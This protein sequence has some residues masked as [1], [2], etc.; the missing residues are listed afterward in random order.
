MTQE[1][2]NFGENIRWRPSAF[3]RPK[4]EAELL[5]ILS[6]HKG[7]KIRPVASKHSWSPVAATTGVTLDMSAFS[8]VE[9]NQGEDDQVFARVGAGCGLQALLDELH[10]GSDWTL[11][12]LGAVKQQTIAGAVSTGT[13][14]SGSPGLSHFVQAARIARYNP[15]SGE[16]EMVTVNGGQE[17]RAVRCGLGCTGVLV[18]LTLSCRPQYLVRE[19]LHHY[20]DLRELLSDTWD[21][22][23]SFFVMLPYT[24]HFVLWRR[25]IVEHRQL[26]FFEKLKARLYRLHK[27]IG[28]D[29]LLHVL[30]TMVKN[31]GFSAHKTFFEVLPKTLP[32][33]R[34]IL[35]ESEA[36][37]TLEHHLFRHVEMEVFVPES[38]LSTA[39]RLLHQ[40]TSVFA[41]E[42][43]AL[44]PDMR[45]LLVADGSLD[46][47]IVKRESY[48]HHY[49]IVC[50]KVLG[51]DTMLSMASGD[52]TWFSI[53]LFSYS[54]DLESYEQ[55]CYWVASVFNRIFGARV[56]WGKH[57]PLE[58]K[59]LGPLY[60]DIEHFKGLCL[61]HDRQGV[62]R[63][64]YVD[65]VLG[66]E[67]LS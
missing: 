15:K 19:S 36:Q 67:E 18:E 23:L 43:D 55:Y 12:T 60:P 8:S 51:E 50:R 32:L 13:H 27:F 54:R 38:E 64:E 65:R 45:E 20:N 2:V 39:L 58:F 17:L 35:D 42:L 26:S 22:P 3:Y 5:D 52:D 6:Q 4:S 40:A 7:E 61:E 41:G 28:P 66:F 21:S 48:L 49:P 29:I 34:P 53:S 30:V 59:A 9:V 16:A 10:R 63:N 47:L 56:H 11:P 25:K 62:F 33:E 24:E 14:G 46:D 57:N 1:I 31:L 37:L 44:T